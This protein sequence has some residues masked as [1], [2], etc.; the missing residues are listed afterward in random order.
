MKAY[1]LYRDRDLD[2]W[3]EVV[4]NE[5]AL[6]QD[7]ELNT[8]Y[9][10]MAQGDAF[11]YD[12]TKRVVPASSIN[13]GEITYRQA[14][15]SDCIT[16]EAVVRQLY[17]I[18]IEGIETKRKCYYGVF[19][20]SPS[21]V[22]HGAR[23][24]IQQFVGV[25]KKLRDVA[26]TQA[27]QFK[28][29]GFAQF[30]SMIQRELTDE[31]FVIIQRCLKE[32]RFNHG[33]LISAGLGQGN[34]G[35]H[36]VLRKPH[37][38]DPNLLRRLFAK[39]PRSLTFHIADRDE[40][41][42]RT[43][44][45]LEARGINL[46][47]NAL[48]QSAEHI[49]SFFTMLRTELAFYIGCVNLHHE[50]TRLRVAVCVPVP[51]ECNERRYAFDGLYDASLALRAKHAPVGNDVAGDGRDLVVITGANQGGK[52]TFLRGVGLAQVMMQ[53]GMFVAAASFSA[54]VCDGIFTH[55]K[56]EEDASMKSGKLDEELKRMSEIVDHI[57]EHSLLLCNESFAATNE[58]EGSE[59]ARQIIAALLRKRVKIV[60]VTHLYAL[61]HGLHEQKAPS[62]M[63]LRAERRADGER[64]FKLTEAEPLHTS[65]GEDLYRRIFLSKYEC[66]EHAE[67]ISVSL[68]KVE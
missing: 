26:D 28:S 45:D 40:A 15:L 53:C 21:S 10:A 23:D 59:I 31:Y 39:W 6:V 14:I 1:L 18:A 2:M 50:L 66:E 44:S 48:A 57:R 17:A 58:R 32:I 30:F 22:L 64:T 27:A 7:L 52:S 62:M 61:A 19:S 16:I 34:K 41:G 51:S 38:K 67:P 54:N 35:I 47:A 37:E 56:R 68:S 43:L 46:V 4:W 8:L 60:L 25:L 24:L 49:L 20:G 36:Y 5:P 65:Y 33:V 29:E 12:V 11:V 9:Q 63:F 13:L 3:Q 55:Y 42:A